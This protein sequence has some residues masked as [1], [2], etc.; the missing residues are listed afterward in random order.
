M[1]KRVD[2]LCFHTNLPSETFIDWTT[3]EDHDGPRS[4]VNRSEV[5]LETYSTSHTQGVSDVY[6]DVQI[7]SYI[8]HQ[9]LYTVSCRCM[10]RPE[11]DTGERVQNDLHLTRRK[12]GTSKRPSRICKIYVCTSK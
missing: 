3:Q 5:V 6:V 9:A 4:A 8:Y 12:G 1:S 2:A 11:V 10:L 7:Y